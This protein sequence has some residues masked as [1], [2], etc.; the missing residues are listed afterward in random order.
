MRRDLFGLGAF[1]VACCAF[2]P[3]L[4]AFVGGVTIAGV[5][6]GGVV[7]ALLVGVGVALAVRTR[8]R[9]CSPLDPGVRS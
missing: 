9:A 8:R 3:V 5:I 7:V 4:V 2:L 6:G 1:A